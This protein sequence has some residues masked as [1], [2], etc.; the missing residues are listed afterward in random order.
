MNVLDLNMIGQSFNQ[1][2]AACSNCDVDGNG[3]INILDLNIVAQ[4]MD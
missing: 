1:S 4:D 3:A 2:A